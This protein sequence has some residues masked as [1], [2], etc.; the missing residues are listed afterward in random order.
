M[1]RSASPDTR[2]VCLRHDS[3]AGL[4]GD[5]PD[6]AGELSGGGDADLVDVDPAAL[7]VSEATA[8][9]HLRLPGM[10]PNGFGLSLL[11]ARKRFAQACRIAVV[12]GRFGSKRRAPALPVLVMPPLRTVLPLERSEGTNP[13]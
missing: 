10:A 2:I 6:E 8:Q 4:A 7:Q 13:R 12:P 1:I 11:P 9:A 5:R 3:G